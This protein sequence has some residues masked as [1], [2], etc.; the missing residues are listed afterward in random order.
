MITIIDV[1]F[2]KL[3]D[4]DESEKQGFA[5]RFQKLD[6]PISGENDGFDIS[7]FLLR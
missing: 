5:C 4:G 7:H 1:L 6:T 2:F 3:I